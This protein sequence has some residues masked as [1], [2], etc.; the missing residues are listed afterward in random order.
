MQWLTV[1]KGIVQCEI[2]PLVHTGKPNPAEL[3]QIWLSLLALNKMVEPHFTMFWREDI[4][5][6]QSNDLNGKTTTVACIAGNLGAARGLHPRRTPGQR[7]VNPTPLF[8]LSRCSPAHAGYFQRQPGK[9]PG[10]CCISSKA[11][12]LALPGRPLSLLLLLS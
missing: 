11:R 6:H 12:A 8:G 10:A 7:S 3:F 5:Q 2:F 1:G 4:A 9:V